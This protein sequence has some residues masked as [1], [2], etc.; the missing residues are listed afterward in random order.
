MR[1][2][3]GLNFEPP[4]IIVSVVHEVAPT[5]LIYSS[6]LLAGEQIAQQRLA[7]D[8][9]AAAQILAVE[10]QQIERPDTSANPW[11]GAAGRRSQSVRPIA[12]DEL[13]INGGTGSRYPHHGRGDHRE[14]VGEVLTRLRKQPHVPAEL[15]ELKPEAVE[16]DLVQPVRPVGGAS[17]RRGLAMGRNALRLITA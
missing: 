6:L 5:S 4:S 16:L 12:D 10:V 7:L 1:L 15:V 3:G 13:A 9:G 2:S 17:T 14:A 11:P 8:Q